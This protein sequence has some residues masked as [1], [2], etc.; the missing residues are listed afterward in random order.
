MFEDEASESQA[1]EEFMPGA[2][3]EE[4][5]RE[6]GEGQAGDLSPGDEVPEAREGKGENQDGKLVAAQIGACAPD[7]VA[8]HYV[9]ERAQCEPEQERA[10][11]GQA[12]KECEE[13]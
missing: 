8:T 4:G 12:G 13:D 9:S 3:S 11:I 1:S 2:H 10:R 7:G 6:A 5:K